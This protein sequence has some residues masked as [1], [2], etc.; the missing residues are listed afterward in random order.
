M[1][2]LENEAALFERRVQS[3]RQ[4]VLVNGDLLHSIVAFDADLAS[5]GQVLYDDVRHILSVRVSL[6]VQ[7]VDGAEYYLVA[8]ESPVLACYG[9]GTNQR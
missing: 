5:R 8:P 6:V 9:L 1:T 3:Y 2:R 7:S 4:P